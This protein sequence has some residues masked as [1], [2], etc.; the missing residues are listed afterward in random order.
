MV[1][2]VRFRNGEMLSYPLVIK[3][4]SANKGSLYYS[5]SD[6]IVFDREA[7]RKVL[8]TEKGSFKYVFLC[9]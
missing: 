8:V 6:V 7:D 9:V 5:D 3:I 1:G 4:D 2:Y